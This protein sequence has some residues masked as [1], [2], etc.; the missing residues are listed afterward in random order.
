MASTRIEKG[1]F[2]RRLKSKLLDEYA[3]CN[4]HFVPD[5][6][7]SQRFKWTLHGQVQVN[8]DESRYKGLTDKLRK[9]ALLDHDEYPTTIANMYEVMVKFDSKSSMSTSRANNSQRIGTVLTQQSQQ[10][11][12]AQEDIEQLVPGN[13]GRTFSIKCFNC[14]KIQALVRWKNT[15][16]PFLCRDNWPDSI[17][18]SVYCPVQ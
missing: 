3:T 15:Y 17:W 18:S 7:R 2:R 4:C 16:V 6:T 13:D 11:R 9:S 1:Y 8:A 5:E 10:D 14:D 12:P